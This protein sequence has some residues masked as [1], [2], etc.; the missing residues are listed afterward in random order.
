MGTKDYI[1]FRLTDS[2]QTDYSYAS[3][4]GGYSLA[5][6]DYDDEFLGVFSISRTI[7]PPIVSATKIVGTL[8]KA[9]AEELGLSESVQVAAGGVDN[10]CM[11]L[12]AGC[13]RSGQMYAS[14]GSSSWIAVSDSKP[15]LEERSTPYVFAHV[16]PEQFVSALAIFS[17]GTAFRWI[18][19][20]LCR[21]LV[22]RSESGGRNTYELMIEEA[23]DSPL[24]SR[25]L[26]FNP[27]LGGGTSLDASS[28]LRG[29]FLG[30]DLGH[31]RGD[32]IRASMEGITLNLLVVLEAFQKLTTTQSHLHV[33]GGGAN[34]HFWRQMYADVMDIC[35]RHINTGQDAAALGAAA[36]AAIAAGLWADFSPLDSIIYSENEHHPIPENVAKY[37]TLQQPFQLDRQFLSQRHHSF[38]N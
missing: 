4:L 17:S 26:L 24:G 23:S 29:A 2:I 22:A 11:A 13:F 33:V 8:T 36:I 12:G 6:W 25:G 21:D 18:R 20:Q 7:L 37:R 32:L 30:L 9:A 14:L 34:S 19:D 10:S 28:E 16:V 3:G 15:L 35:I 38:S 5:K 31:V 27:S 1:N